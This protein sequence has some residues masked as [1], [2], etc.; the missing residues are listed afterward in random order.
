MDDRVK[1]WLDIADEDLSVAKYLV[2][3]NK[4]LYT[5]FMCHQAVEKTLKA[6]IAR[7]CAEDEIPPKIHHLLK[8]ADYA[9]LYEKMSKEQ[10]KF[11]KRLNP[12]NIEAR[13]PEYKSRVSEGL[14]ENICAEIIGET[15]AMLCWIKERL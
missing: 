7:D 11:I 8:L 5:V 3:G 1:H 2:K 14:S 4:F 10:Q 15:E 12:M 13:Y 6:V 9:G